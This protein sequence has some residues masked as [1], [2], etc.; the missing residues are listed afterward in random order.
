LILSNVEGALSEKFKQTREV[1][2]YSVVFKQYSVETETVI[3]EEAL[4]II[5]I[6]D[7]THDTIV[8]S[9]GAFNPYLAQLLT[10]KFLTDF[11]WNRYKGKGCWIAKPD[12]TFTQPAGF[13][14]GSPDTCS[15]DMADCK[16]HAN[17]AR[18]NAFPG[19]PGGGGY[20]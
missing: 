12:G 5:G 9:V 16:R 18:L 2:G 4:E 13:T 11:C 20:V 7:I 19:I 15:H 6:E 3:F 17:I 10:E 14:L 8:L 1:E